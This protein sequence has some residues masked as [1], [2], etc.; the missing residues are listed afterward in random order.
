MQ[1]KLLFIYVIY[2]SMKKQKY[3]KNLFMTLID[4]YLIHQ[5]IHRGNHN[6]TGKIQIDFNETIKELDR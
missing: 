2:L 1:N 4:V 3:V 5:L 6:L